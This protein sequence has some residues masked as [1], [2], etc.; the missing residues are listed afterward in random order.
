MVDAQGR[1]E[2][3]E[4]SLIEKGQLR[5]ASRLIASSQRDGNNHAPTRQAQLLLKKTAALSE[6]WRREIAENGDLDQRWITRS[7]MSG[8]LRSGVAGFITM[9]RDACKRAAPNSSRE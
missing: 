2:P 8:L 6:T 1:E 5:R 3:D 4:V 9:H 7:R